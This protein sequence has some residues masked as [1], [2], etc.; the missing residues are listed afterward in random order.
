MFTNYLKSLWRYIARNKGFTFINV[1]GLA[2][3]MLACML[4]AQFV[5]HELS[6][7]NFL[8]NKDR[9][10]RLQLDRY[11]KGEIATRWASGAAGIGPDIKASFPEVRE[12]VRLHRRVST[13]STGDVFFKE[14]DV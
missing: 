12:Y 4:I 10:F 6:Y 3:G 9:I 7:D 14:E 11:N 1:S 8:E 5:L 13:L 2:I